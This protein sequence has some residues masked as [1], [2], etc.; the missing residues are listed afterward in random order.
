MDM[1]PNYS[2]RGARALVTLHEEYLWSFV[3]MWRQANMLGVA[4][5][6]TEDPDYRS[7]ETLLLHVLTSA[8]GY[9][10]WMCEQLELPDP[11]ID[12]P[13]AI[14]EIEEKIEG[15]IEHLLDRWR[16]PLVDIEEERFGRP[17]YV[18]NWG[19]RYCIDSM[20]EH[21]VMHPI[22]HLFQLMELMGNEEDST[23]PFE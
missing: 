20:L 13:P 6:E 8:R 11:K 5:P 16:V 9:M 15:Y 14:E 3:E 1:I 21:A 18:S 10:V 2:Y 22:R 4:L 23:P 7:M 19:V 17:E 12:P